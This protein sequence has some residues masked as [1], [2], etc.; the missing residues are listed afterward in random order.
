MILEMHK[1]GW[2]QRMQCSACVSIRKLLPLSIK[3]KKSDN[4]RRWTPPA[5]RLYAFILRAGVNPYLPRV[6]WLGCLQ[7]RL[8]LQGCCFCCC[9]CC[10]CC[11][12]CR[13]TCVPCAATARAYLGPRCLRMAGGGGFSTCSSVS[14]SSS[15][16]GLPARRP[17]EVPCVCY[18]VYYSLR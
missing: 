2:S 5:L 11:Y 17:C 9:C 15:F 1:Q 4:A 12:S 16:R 3:Q 7:P 14:K 10:C 13:N 8:Q 6:G 18:Y